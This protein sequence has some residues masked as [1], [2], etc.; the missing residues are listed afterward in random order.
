MVRPS[1]ILGPTPPHFLLLTLA[2]NYSESLVYCLLR[3]VVKISQNI[4]MRNWPAHFQLPS[5]CSNCGKTRSSKQWPLRIGDKNSLTSN[6]CSD[7]KSCFV[8]V[9]RVV[10]NT[11][12]HSRLKLKI[13]NPSDLLSLNE[14]PEHCAN[15]WRL[16]P[17]YQEG[18]GVFPTAGIIP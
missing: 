12:L 2:S 13:Q 7:Q 14:T 11:F 16:S 15:E 3:L 1:P 8:N 17:N 4:Y 9:P 18:F 5:E 10:M 6:M